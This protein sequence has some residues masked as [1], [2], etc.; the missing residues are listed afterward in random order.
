MSEEKRKPRQSETV[1]VRVK[2]K[3]GQLTVGAA[4]EGVQPLNPGYFLMERMR[5]EA[6]PKERRVQRQKL[7]DGNR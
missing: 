1:A 7:R 4:L 5:T 6:R 3:L 2:R